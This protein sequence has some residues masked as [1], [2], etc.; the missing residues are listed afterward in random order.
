[1]KKSTKDKVYK[2]TEEDIDDLKN[3]FN[4]ENF[5]SVN[6]SQFEKAASEDISLGYNIAKMFDDYHNDV[7]LVR[8]VYKLEKSKF[9]T[10]KPDKL[11]D[12]FKYIIKVNT[13]DD[14]NNTINA[15][16]NYIRDFTE[17]CHHIS[18]DV[19]KLSNEL[20]IIKRNDPLFNKALCTDDEKKT[21]SHSIRIISSITSFISFVTGNN[22]KYI[23]AVESIYRKHKNSDKE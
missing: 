22:I 23:N 7:E 21:I 15:I 4:D 16:N 17:V 10:T 9:Y 6:L 1:L 2:F 14:I 18:E 12:D 5:I 13:G 11:L 20:S 8:V 3:K 19:R